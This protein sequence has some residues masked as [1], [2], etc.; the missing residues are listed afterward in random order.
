MNKTLE[1][2][3]ALPYT[4]ELVPD[5]D[6]EGWFVAVKELP[7]CISQGDSE[8]EAL[9]MIHDAMEG[10][11]AVALEDGMKIPEPETITMLRE[12][13]KQNEPLQVQNRQS[14]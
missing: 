10:W 13:I 2:Y 12:H 5:P 11:I 1:Y 9:E 4:F 8:K 14:E 6:D 3:L 7:G